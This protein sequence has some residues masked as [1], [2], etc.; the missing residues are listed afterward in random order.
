MTGSKLV[1][2]MPSVKRPLLFEQTNEVKPV[3]DKKRKINVG[4][5]DSDD[6]LIILEADGLGGRPTGSQSNP[7]WNEPGQQVGPPSPVTSSE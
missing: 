4:R 1:F 6:E 5:E 3:V 7:K 2:G